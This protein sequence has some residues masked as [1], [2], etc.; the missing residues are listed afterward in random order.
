MRPSISTSYKKTVKASSSKQKPVSRFPCKN[1]VGALIINKRWCGLF[2][3][4]AVITISSRF[5]RHGV[6]IST[7]HFRLLLI[8]CPLFFFLHLTALSADAQ[9]IR[10]RILYWPVSTHLKECRTGGS[11]R[12]HIFLSNSY[13]EASDSL[14]FPAG[15]MP[16]QC[17]FFMEEDQEEKTAKKREIPLAKDDPSASL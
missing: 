4:L 15:H 11:V 17:A 2:Y 5:P 3:Q 7:K 14:G 9:F 10:G 6:K 13:R 1:Q 8:P 16:R 12:P